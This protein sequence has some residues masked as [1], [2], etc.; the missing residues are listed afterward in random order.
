M[1]ENSKYY[2]IKD[3]QELFGCGRSKAYDIIALPMFPKMRIGKTFY[4]DK[5]EFEKWRNKN[6]YSAV[7]L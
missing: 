7:L 3:I 5:A 1:T 6:L 4:I 2:S